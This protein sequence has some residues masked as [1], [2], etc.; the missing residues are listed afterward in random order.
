MK[1]KN[2]DRPPLRG[3]S[4]ATAIQCASIIFSAFITIYC[5]K[6]YYNPCNRI[7]DLFLDCNHLPIF[8]ISTIVISWSAVFAAFGLSVN[9]NDATRR[10]RTF[11]LVMGFRTNAFYNQ[12][13]E[14][15][16]SF[17]LETGKN[18]VK[19]SI[20]DLKE[21]KKNA[22]EW[23]YS[24]QNPKQPNKP[25][26][27]SIHV[28]ASFYEFSLHS[29]ENGDLDHDIFYNT[30]RGLMVRFYQMFE[31]IILDSRDYDENQVPRSKTY[32]FLEAYSRKWVLEQDNF[33]P[34]SPKRFLEIKRRWDDESG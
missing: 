16:Y 31:I 33:S 30:C 15:Y 28:I 24:S 25:P 8:V 10:N 13:R 26:L 7:I 19:A 9:N 29:I 14:N 11:D 12:H 5:V 23:D 3:I 32:E 4:K 20:K 34:M 22:D 21:L 18:D 27:E 2:I 6:N 17:K 1:N